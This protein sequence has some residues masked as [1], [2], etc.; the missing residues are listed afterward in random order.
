M[1]PEEWLKLFWTAICLMAVFGG[2]M[3]YSIMQHEASWAAAEA[4]G[5]ILAFGGA[6]QTH[7]GWQPKPPAAWPSMPPQNPDL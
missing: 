2:A 4:A 3:V 6:W 7:K 1:K 5:F